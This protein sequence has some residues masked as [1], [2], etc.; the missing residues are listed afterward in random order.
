MVAGVF[1]GIDLFTDENPSYTATA[2]LPGILQKEMPERLFMKS[3]IF[4]SIMV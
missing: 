3:N 4:V 2:E 1:R